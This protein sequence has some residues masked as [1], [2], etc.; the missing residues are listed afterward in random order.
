[1]AQAAEVLV[2]PAAPSHSVEDHAPPAIAAGEGASEIVLVLSRPVAAQHRR[3]HYLL[4][5]LERLGVN[6]GLV[7]TIG[8][9]GA[10]PAH[11][12]DVVV[13]TEHSM[14]LRARERFGCALGS[15]A[16][17][18]SDLIEKVSQ[19]GDRV[20]ATRV[21]LEGHLYEGAAVWIDRNCAYFA[22]FDPLAGIDVADRGFRDG[23]AV[24]ELAL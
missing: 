9:L 11:N 17:S 24:G 12:A 19:I 15:L 22:A 16:A 14:H 8:V 20:V 1:M 5:T 3:L 18:Q 13:V 21:C 4:H 7:A 6:Q 2:D 23:S 10:V